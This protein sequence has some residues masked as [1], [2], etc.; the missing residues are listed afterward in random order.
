MTQM[1]WVRNSHPSA[2]LRLCT[3]RRQLINMGSEPLV[4]VEDPCREGPSFVAVEQTAI[5]LQGRTATSRVHKNRVVT[6]ER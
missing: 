6:V 2:D 1:T 3:G 5:V 4:N